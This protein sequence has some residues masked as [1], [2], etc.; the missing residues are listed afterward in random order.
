M[1]K[2][3]CRCW[4]I[5]QRQRLPK[6]LCRRGIVGLPHLQKTQRKIKLPLFFLAHG[7]YALGRLP[8]IDKGQTGLAEFFV[9]TPQRQ[10]RVRCRVHG[11]GLGKVL[12]S[13]FIQ[14]GSI[15]RMGCGKDN[16]PP[17]PRSLQGPPKSPL[18]A[19]V[20]AHVGEGIAKAFFR[21]GHIL[22][23]GPWAGGRLPPRLCG[24]C[25]IAQCGIGLRQLHENIYFF[26][27]INRQA[28]RRL[29]RRHC[30]RRFAGAHGG[31]GQSGGQ[32][33]LSL[34]GQGRGQRHGF[35]KGRIR[36]R[37]IALSGVDIAER[38]QGFR[39]AQRRNA[40]AQKSREHVDGLLFLVR[41]GKALPCPVQ[42][43]RL[44]CGNLGIDGGR[45]RIAGRQKQAVGQNR[46]IFR[47]RVQLFQ[48]GA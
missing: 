31:K 45:F 29:Q 24:F 34:L 14:P 48:P 42:H 1:P 39:L 3:R 43:L 32:L 46:G 6:R 21:K 19:D 13:F 41:R 2:T 47:P 28:Q 26:S 40:G 35:M 36:L 20:V 27:R 15:G 12:Q 17:G 7:G 5:A 9:C 37:G 33:R 23:C 8:V 18:G 22:A 30:L 11:C 4:V 25:R 16:A 38:Q 10:R 44:F